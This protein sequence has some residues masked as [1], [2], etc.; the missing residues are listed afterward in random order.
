[1]PQDPSRRDS[2]PSPQLDSKNPRPKRQ[3]KRLFSGIQPTGEIHIGNYLGALERWGKLADSGEYDAIFCIVDYHAITADY[4]PVGLQQR[5]FDAAAMIM[6]CGI[7]PENSSLFV[8][9]RVPQHTELTWILNC[10]ATIGEL[11]RMTQFKDKSEGKDSVSVGLFDYP[12]LQIADIVLY[13][14]QYVP[15]GEDQLQHLELSREVVRRFNKRFGDVFPEPQALLGEAK[16]VMGLDGQ[17]K[18]SKSL[19]NTIALAEKPESIWQKLSVAKT[20]E[21]RKRRSDPGVPTDCNIY[22]S[23]HRYFTPQEELEHIDRQCRSAG[24]GCIECKKM[25]AA[26]ME[27]RL[28]PIR[29]RYERLRDNPDEVASFLQKSARRCRLIARRTMRQVREKIG[30]R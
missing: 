15:V 13:Q 24:I 18:M 7:A 21:R 23:F 22:M 6:A 28:A 5:I 9:S 3:S 1:M 8:Q 12:V 26:N 2:T 11:S 10:V 25:L 16:R 30:V 4:D 19:N 20:D 14:A 29:T 17:S 27:K